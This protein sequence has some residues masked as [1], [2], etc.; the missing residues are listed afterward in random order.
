MSPPL[1]AASQRGW[2]YDG[3]T[4]A[5]ENGDAVPRFLPTP[6]DDIVRLLHYRDRKFGV[7]RLQFLK[8]GHVRPG[9]TEPGQEIGEALLTLFVLR[10]AI[11]IPR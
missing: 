11:F 7:C 2:G 4:I 1:T 9:A 6:N 5:T 8:A 3:F 10:V